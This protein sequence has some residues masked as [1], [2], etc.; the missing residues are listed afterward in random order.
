LSHAEFFIHRLYVLANSL[1]IIS[2]CFSKVSVSGNSFVAVSERVVINNKIQQIGGFFFD[3]G[4]K[5]CAATTIEII[6]YDEGEGIFRKI[7]REIDL[8][9]ERHA[10]LELSKGKLTTDPNNHSG[11]GIFFFIT[12]V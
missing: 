2:A 5:L 1:A 12:H 9:D 4:I 3:T 8:T 6:I 11:V 7:Q 10:V